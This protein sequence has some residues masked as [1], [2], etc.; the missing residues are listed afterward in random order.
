MPRIGDDDGGYAKERDE[1]QKQYPELDRLE[2]IKMMT[3]KNL[4]AARLQAIKDKEEDEAIRIE[5]QQR[6]KKS[7]NK[8]KKSTN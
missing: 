6:K 8:K 4:E 1:L 3:R 7:S 5:E 2:I